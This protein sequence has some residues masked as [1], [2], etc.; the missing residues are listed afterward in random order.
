[1]C[2]E[3]R[4]RGMMCCKLIAN[5]TRQLFSFHSSWAGIVF[6]IFNVLYLFYIFNAK[7]K[8]KQKPV[9][10]FW[11]N[12]SFSISSSWINFYFAIW[13]LF[14]FTCSCLSIY[15]SKEEKFACKSLSLQLRENQKISYVKQRQGDWFYDNKNYEISSS[16]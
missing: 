4:Q 1:M 7:I 5:I 3:C 14:H 2:H 9:L 12:V 15:I 16:F 8:L 10:H 13:Q 11:K 6:Y